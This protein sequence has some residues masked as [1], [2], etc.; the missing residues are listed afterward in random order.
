[1]VIAY[2]T[3]GSAKMIKLTR[4]RCLPS[5]SS[6]AEASRLFYDDTGTSLILRGNAR[7]V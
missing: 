5:F 3:Q 6:G 2:D 7:E 1:M 4:E